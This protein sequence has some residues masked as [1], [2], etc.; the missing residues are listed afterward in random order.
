MIY[1]VE[2]DASIRGLEDVYKRQ[3]QATSKLP[4]SKAS[5][6]RATERVAP[7]RL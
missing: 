2:D 5:M 6:Y 7:L 4:S 3:A 1:I